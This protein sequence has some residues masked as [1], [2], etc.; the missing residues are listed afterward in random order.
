MAAAAEMAGDERVRAALEEE[1]TGNQH[2]RR[3]AIAARALEALLR[4]LLGEE[5]ESGQVC[6][7]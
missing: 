3:H 7:S 2:R 4:P 5:D 6:G 1:N